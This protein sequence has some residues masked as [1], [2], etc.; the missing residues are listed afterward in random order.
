MDCNIRDAGTGSL[1]HNA[2]SITLLISRK[3]LII[4]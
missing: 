1:S 3:S 4:A 2:L